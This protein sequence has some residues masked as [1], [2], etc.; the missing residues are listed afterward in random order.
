ML[1]VAFTDLSCAKDLRSTLQFDRAKLG[2]FVLG[3]Q[4]EGIRILS[5]GTWYLSAAHTEEDIDAAI[6]A[7][8][9]TL[10]SMKGHSST[11]A[12]DGRRQE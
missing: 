1:H 10:K 4:E 5:R 2:K 3:L 11:R 6:K 12:N 7:A 8:T 9:E